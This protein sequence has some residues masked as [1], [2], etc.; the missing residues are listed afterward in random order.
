MKIL[1]YRYGS[2]CEP[3]VIEAFKGAGVEVVEETAEMTDKSI[4]YKDTVGIVDKLLRCDSF[5]F[6]FSINYFPALSDICN[7][8]KVHYVSWTVDSPIQELFSP[9][10]AN[11]YSYIFMFDHAQ[12]EYFRQINPDNI[13]YLPLAANVSR[14]DKVLAGASQ[15]DMSKFNCDISFVG[16]LYSEKNPYSEVAGLSPHSTGYID[17]LINAQLSL[18]GCNII[19]DS[20]DDNIVKDFVRAVPQ[21][22]EPHSNDKRVIPYLIANNYIGNEIAVRE[23][24]HYLTLAADK[25]KVSLYTYSNSDSIPKI[26]N[27]GGAKTHTEMPLIFNNSKINL[28]ITI[29]P[30]QTGLSLRVFDICACGGFLFTN[31]Q[32]ELPDFYNIGEEV[33][34]Y[35]S[36]EE[37]LD[38]LNYY[39]THDK[40]RLAIAR[41]GYEKTVACHTYQ[42]RINEM[43]RILLEHY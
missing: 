39:M 14:Y 36:E 43:M 8:H 20:L 23:R 24:Q 26:I 17:G 35:A 13:F 9:S 7:I 22:A 27:K 42:H 25:Y 6:V 31:Y 28:N 3:D 2:I 40:E 12:Y 41:K 11:P 38:K 18:F 30:I 32:A 4:T 5:I 34:A 15:A 10:L 16:S 33:E 19:E 21:L 29:R 37:F 1:F